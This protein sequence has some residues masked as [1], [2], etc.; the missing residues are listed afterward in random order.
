MVVIQAVTKVANIKNRNR[1]IRPWLKKFWDRLFLAGGAK[2][3]WDIP[4]LNGKIFLFLYQV[5]KSDFFVIN[6][7]YFIIRFFPIAVIGVVDHLGPT[8]LPHWDKWW[9]ISKCLAKSLPNPREQK[10]LKN[11]YNS[12]N[13]PISTVRPHSTLSLCPRKT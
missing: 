3:A 8:L 12:E 2:S 4:Y 13:F 5:F 11:H 9:L 7:S 1:Q 10:E 6:F